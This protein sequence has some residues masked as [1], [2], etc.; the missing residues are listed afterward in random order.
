MCIFLTTPRSPKDCELKF[1]I[2][3]IFYTCPVLYNLLTVIRIGRWSSYSRLPRHWNKL[4]VFH[5]LIAGSCVMGTDHAP[6]YLTLGDYI[7]P[8]FYIGNYYFLTLFWIQFKSTIVFEW[9]SI[10]KKENQ[11]FDWLSTNNKLI[12]FSLLMQ[13]HHISSVC[14]K[15]IRLVEMKQ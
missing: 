10:L 11:I 6:S 2:F 14:R 4:T 15:R 8:K 12:P 9:T 3:L 13:P 5:F 1:D 7:D